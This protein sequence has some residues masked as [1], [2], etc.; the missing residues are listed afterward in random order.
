MYEFG[1]DLNQVNALFQ[2]G[3]G[4]RSLLEKNFLV[5]VGFVSRVFLSFL[6]IVTQPRD[7]SLLKTV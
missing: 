5:I 3:C 7:I 2:I 4:L 1:K 6:L